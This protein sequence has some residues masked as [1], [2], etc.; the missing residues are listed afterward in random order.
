[1]AEKVSRDATRAGRSS[2]APERGPRQARCQPYRIVARDS[3]LLRK[4]KHVQWKATQRRTVRAAQRDPSRGQYGWLRGAHGSAACAGGPR[5][6]STQRCACNGT[7]A[8]ALR[9][10]HYMVQ[11]VWLNGAPQDLRRSAKW[12]IAGLMVAAVDILL[13]ELRLQHV[14]LVGGI[15]ALEGALTTA[16]ERS[17]LPRALLA[18]Y[19]A[20]GHGK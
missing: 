7:A 15:S 10:I 9:C 6:T 5:C 3:R 14:L 20:L 18:R 1:M 16:L 12:V 17:L 13:R 19:A 2:G 11:R 4:L 8:P